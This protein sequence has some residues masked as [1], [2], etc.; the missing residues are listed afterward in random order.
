MYRKRYYGAI[1]YKCSKIIRSQKTPQ[2][3]DCQSVMSFRSDTN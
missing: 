3:T 2:I 1:I